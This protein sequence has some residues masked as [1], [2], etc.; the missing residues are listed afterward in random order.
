MQ[1]ELLDIL[2]I[3]CLVL[4]FASTYKKRATRMVRFWTVGWL[5]IL[6]HFAA[7]LFHPAGPFQQRALLAVCLAALIACGIVFLLAAGSPA[8]PRRSHLA[9]PLLAGA[10]GTAFILL[11]I[12]DVQAAWPYTLAVFA[13]ALAWCGYSLALRRASVLVRALLLLNNFASTGW[14]FWSILHHRQDVGVNAILC[15]LYLSLGILYTGAF[16]RISAGAVTVVFGLLAWAA[17]FPAGE[18]CQH[19]G[20]AA[21]ISPELW[22]VP[23]YFV[24]FGMILVLLEEEIVA[25]GAASKHYRLLF[26]A[27]PLPMWICDP[28]T[29]RFLAVNDAAL[30]QYGYSRDEFLS[31][32]LTSIRTECDPETLRCEINTIG[33]CQQFLGQR[34]HRR[35]NGSLFPVDIAAHH[36]QIDGRNA[37][38]SLIQDVTERQQ[39]HER[40]FHQAHHD[41]L[42]GIP[43]RAWIE[44]KLRDTLAAAARHS[45]Q[46]ALLCLDLDRFKQI[47][48]T[49]GHATGDV[50]LREAASRLDQLARSLDPAAAVAR[51]GG[52]EFIL[53][54]H[55]IPSCLHAEQVARDLLV[56]LQAPI[57]TDGHAIELTASIG[58][59]FFPNDGEDEATLW[60][61]ADSA[62]Y[63]AKR[64][65]GNQFLCMSPEISLLASEANALELRLRHAL[66]AGGLELQ[67]QPLYKID[68]TLNSLEALVRLRDADGTLISPA[69]FV[70]VAEESGL[71]V[72]LGAWVLNEVCRQTTAWLQDGLPAV[73]IAL[74]ISPLQITRP[75]FAAHVGQVLALHTMEPSLLAMEITETAMMRNTGEAAR[76]MKILAGLGI[77]FSVDDFGTGYSSLGQLDKL[78][79]HSLKIDRTFIRR[80]CRPDG[81]YSIV[82]AVI[83]MAHSLRLEVVAEGVETYEQWSALR[84][85]NCDVVQGFLFSSPLTAEEVPALLRASHIPYTLP[86]PQDDIRV[87]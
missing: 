18:F 30:A 37:A 73:P 8:D 67:Y 55:D 20:I 51:V 72:P 64:A 62:M 15:Q 59:A 13:G 17:V 83:S 44:S 14:L 77:G 74:N 24:A 6:V 48:D 12:W 45:R 71:I 22:N 66:R 7:L 40:L 29:L 57:P 4:L 16:R 80:M 33:P 43:N 27:N 70:P 21:S 11:A 42:T 47:N 26:E 46:A 60:R 31:I 52:E 75:D 79:V 53:L 84:Q 3:G 68:G 82:N 39:L 69:R 76:Q 41:L 5:L 61:N 36:V 35:K 54:L 1:N 32:S 10:A 28:E 9:A 63:R 2:I 25:A 34:L 58:I 19:L 87:A 49:Y 81:T 56:A 85:L 38:F 23:K 50:C 86:L 65:G 78:P